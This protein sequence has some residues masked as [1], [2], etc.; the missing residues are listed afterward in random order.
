[1]RFSRCLLSGGRASPRFV[2]WAW[3][4]PGRDNVHMLCHFGSSNTLCEL[5]RFARIARRGHGEQAG[6]FVVWDRQAFDERMQDILG[7]AAL[8]AREVLQLFVGCLL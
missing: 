5:C 2:S 6:F 3:Y 8:A 7:D 1:M 4:R